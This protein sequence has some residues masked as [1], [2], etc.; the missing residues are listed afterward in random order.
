MT[1][2]LEITIQK[3][4][5]GLVKPWSQTGIEL[6][7]L[8]VKE[9][10]R[11]A[12]IANP[13]SVARNIERNSYAQLVDTNPKLR[14][15]F[16][17]SV[18]KADYRSRAPG[19]GPII[20][21]RVLTASLERNLLMFG[22]E[23]LRVNPKPKVIQTERETI[24]T[25]LAKRWATKSTDIIEI[26]SDRKL[27][28]EKFIRSIGL[29]SV[30]PPERPQRIKELM[31][32]GKPIV[33]NWICPM[34]TPLSWDSKTE[35]LYR[36]YT[37]TTPEEGFNRDYQLLPR[38][39]LEN[40]LVRQ[41]K[42]F[43]STW[44]YLKI[45]ADDNP[46]CLY[47]ACLR[48]DG[49]EATVNAIA[50]Y[51]SYVQTRLDS[52]TG[53]GNIWVLPW[54]ELLGPKLFDDYLETYEGIKIEDL[55]P[56]LPKDIIETEIDILTDHTKP[57]PILLPRFRRFAED[58]VRYFAVE[59]LFLDKLFGDEVIVAWNDSTRI[60]ATIDPLRKING[61]APLPKIFVLHNKKD[62]ELTDN[63]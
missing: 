35:R 4:I 3:A 39:S 21:R 15:P 44:T 41:L 56:Y 62:G 36:R 13:L 11:A 5:E 9:I 48:I 27:A 10:A 61:L 47:P 2:E 1:P 16:K 43:N 49:R 52:L 25:R 53:K 45:V 18:R 30:V 32:A 7:M 60:S 46:F 33:V 29:L 57:D 8:T 22:T 20:K 40:N 58:C 31:A 51:S 50:N 63:Y 55:L 23:R 14:A 59:G 26:D 19:G 28:S 42:H 37:Q 24:K 54:S 38:L 6:P 12:K 34:G 17:K